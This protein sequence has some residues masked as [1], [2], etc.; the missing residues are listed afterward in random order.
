MTIDSSWIA[1]L[2]EEVPGAFTPHP[3]FRPD[4]VFVDGQIRLMC[5]AVEGLVT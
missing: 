2:K 4:A 5:P 3:P 1:C